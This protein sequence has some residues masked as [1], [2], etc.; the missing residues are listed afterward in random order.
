MNIRF[1]YYISLFLC[2]STTR[3]TFGMWVPI[4][5]ATDDTIDCYTIDT[6]N[7]RW[8][9]LPAPSPSS[10]SI[11][12]HPRSC[13]RYT[14]EDQSQGSTVLVVIHGSRHPGPDQI[15]GPH[16]P[17]Y[18]NPHCLEDQNFRHI[19]RFAAH[20]AQKHKTTVDLVSFKWSGIIDETVRKATALALTQYLEKHYSHA[21]VVILSHSH[22][23]TVTNLA[24]QFISNPIKLLIQFACPV[25]STQFESAKNPLEVTYK[26]SNLYSDA[27]PRNFETLVYFY[28]T[29]DFLAAGAALKKTDLIALLANTL[30]M[31]AYALYQRAT[32]SQHTT[33][34]TDYIQNI[35][36]YFSLLHKSLKSAYIH[37][38]QEGK[39]IVG[40]RTQI[41]LCDAGHSSI[42]DTV[43]VLPAVFDIL[44]RDYAVNYQASSL[45]DLHVDLRQP[46]D[47]FHLAVRKTGTH[48]HIDTDISIKDILQQ[49]EALSMLQAQN[50]KTAYQRDLSNTSHDYP[51]IVSAFSRLLPTNKS[52]IMRYFTKTT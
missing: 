29:G 45:F 13:Y 22:G 25:R 26:L 2:M 32:Q 31:G 6:S 42:L 9:Q 4:D 3:T 41:N 46:E 51:G 33:S 43:K 35:R 30:G 10:L 7:S 12:G 1:F 15:S 24:S 38:L 16:N 28:S 11:A 23:C 5:T 34:P 27:T 39:T 52:T 36:L 8:R 49:E 14:P 19:M 18:Y 50:F 17:T 40:I 48:A 44:E 47:T 20:Y 37:P 21:S